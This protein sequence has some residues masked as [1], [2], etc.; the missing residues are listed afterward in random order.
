MLHP[1]TLENFGPYHIHPVGV[2]VFDTSRENVVF[3][4]KPQK[5]WD[6]VI[7]KNVE[8]YRLHPVEVVVF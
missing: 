3:C 5:M 8:P 2:V 1:V 4:C 7:L 6:P